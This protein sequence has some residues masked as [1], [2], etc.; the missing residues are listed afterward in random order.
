MSVSLFIIILGIGFCSISI[1]LFNDGPFLIGGFAGVCGL[2]LGIPLTIFG[3]VKLINV[4]NGKAK[5][6]KSGFHKTKYFYLG[7]TEFL[8]DEDHKKICFIIDDEENHPHIYN[9]S[10]LISYDTNYD[11]RKYYTETKTSYKQEKNGAVGRAV[12]GGALFGVAG[13]VVGAATAPTTITP[14]TKTTSFKTSDSISITIQLKNGEKTV[15]ERLRISGKDLNETMMNTAAEV[16][17]MLDQII[18]INK[19]EK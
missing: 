18:E 6:G 3:I 11:W 7:I 13:A 10:D 4:L 9:Y 16:K 5:M 1:W 12:V 14:E 19:A 8:I 2:L 17:H 15:T